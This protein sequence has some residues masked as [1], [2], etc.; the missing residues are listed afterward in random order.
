VV[1]AINDPSGFRNTP[2]VL[3]FGSERGV[4]TPCRFFPL[5]DLEENFQTM[6]AHRVRLDPAAVSDQIRSMRQIQVANVGVTCVVTVRYR[7]KDYA[8]FSVRPNRELAH[9]C[10]YVDGDTPF[11]EAAIDELSEEFLVMLGEDTFCPSQSFGFPYRAKTLPFYWEVNIREN[12]ERLA[13]V[14]SLHSDLR[15]DHSN[16]DFSGGPQGVSSAPLHASGAGIYIDPFSSSAQVVY[17]FAVSLESEISLP[18]SLMHSEDRFEAGRLV[19]EV[20][21]PLVLVELCSGSLVEGYTLQDGELR[22]FDLEGMRFHVGMSEVGAD[23]VCQTE[24]ISWEG[25]RRYRVRAAAPFLAG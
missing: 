20:R 6:A 3:Q 21:S 22:P 2:K 8:V 13:W 23:G 1:L 9:I 25:L 15:Y 7:S 19:T 14:P 4:R 17:H 24:S 18:V 11:R 10:G 12:P 16:N 5:G